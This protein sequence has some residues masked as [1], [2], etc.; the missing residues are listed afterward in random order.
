MQ[1][2]LGVIAVACASL[3]LPAT[4]A[5]ASKTVYAGG[6]VKFQNQIGNATGGGVD[7]FLI[8][9]VTVNVGGTVVWNGKALANGFHTVNFPKAG[10]KPLPLVGPTGK[11]YS[12]VLDAAGSPFWFNGQPQLGFN[13]ALFAAFGGKTYNGSAAVDSGLPLG[14][15][16][17][18]K[19]TFTKA[20]VYKYY[21][22]VHPGMSGFVVVKPKG[23][24]VP[25]AQQDAATLAKAEKAAVTEAK[26]LDKTKPTGS[27]VSVGAS[28]PGGVEVFAMFPGKL[29]IKS[30]TTVTFAMSK[31]SR[32]VHTATFGPLGKTGYVTQLAQAFAQSQVFPGNAIYPSDPPGSITLNPTSHGNGFANVGVMDRDSATAQI[33]PSGKI[34]FSAPGT[35]NFICLV[36]PFMHGTVVVTP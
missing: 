23:A 19:L 14:K 21:C 32:E 12:G 22:N 18:F 1:R 11:T 31:L 35:Y 33:P 30:G 5:A 10:G 36:H 28:G 8:N 25:T 3:A 15:P 24:T 6:S 2:R 17:D 4:A 34:T 29:T 9:R 13:P 16:K 20:G 26:G 27:N 7:N